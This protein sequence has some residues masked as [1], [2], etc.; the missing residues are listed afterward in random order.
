MNQK[1]EKQDRVWNEFFD[2]GP[3]LKTSILAGG[4]PPRSKWF[5]RWE[6]FLIN[7]MMGPRGP[8]RILCMALSWLTLVVGFMP[9]YLMYR[10]DL[11]KKRWKAWR[12]S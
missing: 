11:V 9:E 1:R 4:L 5:D 2:Q 7:G 3:D 6:N 8:K 10:I 12:E